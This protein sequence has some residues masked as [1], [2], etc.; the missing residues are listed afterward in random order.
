MS[1]RSLYLALY[2]LWQLVYWRPLWLLLCTLPSHAQYPHRPLYFAIG[3]WPPYTSTHGQGGLLEPIIQDIFEHAGYQVHFHYF[4][5]VRSLKLVDRGKYHATFPWYR[6]E[7]HSSD[8]L[9]SPSPINHTRTVFF[10]R[11]ST[12]LHWQTFAD[13][14]AYRIGSVGGYTVTKRLHR[15]D[16]TTLPSMDQHENFQKLYHGRV[17]L[18]AA[19]ERVGA[20]WVAKVFREHAPSVQRDPH[21]VLEE[22][23]HVLFHHNAFGQELSHVFEQGLQRLITS[24]C[25][26]ALLNRQS[27]QKQ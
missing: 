6:S 14:A 1:P 16:V 19:E 21:P 22:P 20:Y 24:G 4:P 23:M 9:V 5:W 11:Q 26:R 17:D 13:L 3:E 7:I 10:H 15:H 18:I 12:P 2:R 25:Y 8:L 27:C